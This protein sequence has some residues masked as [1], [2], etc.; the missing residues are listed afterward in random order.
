MLQISAPDKFE[1]LYSKFDFHCNFLFKGLRPEE[2]EYIEES[3]ETMY[4]R[5]NSLI[6]HE[7]GIPTGIY[8][9]RRGRVKKYKSTFNG[10]TQIFYIYKE[11]DLLGYH[12]LLCEERYGDSCEAIDDCEVGFISSDIF[13]VLITA[14]PTFRM[15]IIKN[16]S[17]EFGVMANTISLLAQKSQAVRLAN[18]LLVFENRF[19][20]QNRKE[21]GIDLSRDDLSNVIGTTRESLGRTLKQFREENLIRVEDRKIHI[22][23]AN[24]LYELIADSSP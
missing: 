16:M 11:G 7:G 17:H 2:R 10:Q 1:K 20:V 12:S 8:F 19:N 24:R 21:Y 15:S 6:F 18:F 23:D 22:A 13:D 14:I 5:K 9:I 3:M 4:F